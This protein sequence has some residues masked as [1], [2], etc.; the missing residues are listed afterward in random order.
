ME[1]GTGVGRE[2]KMGVERKGGR[3]GGW[4]WAGGKR[5]RRREEEGRRTVL[6][7]LMYT[8]SG[9][10]TL[11]IIGKSNS[12]TSWSRRLQSVAAMR[13]TAQA[14][15]T[16][17]PIDKYQVNTN[18][19]DKSTYTYYPQWYWN[20]SKWNIHVAVPNRNRI[21]FCCIFW[22]HHQVWRAIALSFR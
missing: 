13:C 10:A 8:G 16:A 14:W 17:L 3:M 9:V 15:S 1:G 6:T 4:E 7:T 22:A 18:Q 19:H 11:R 21:L 12:L 5:N 2:R 20:Y